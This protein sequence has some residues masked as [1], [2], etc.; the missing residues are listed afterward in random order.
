MK[1]SLIQLLAGQSMYKEMMLRIS[2]NEKREVIKK[3]ELDKKLNK[4]D[5]KEK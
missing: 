4:K 3:E 5:G 2:E 1:E